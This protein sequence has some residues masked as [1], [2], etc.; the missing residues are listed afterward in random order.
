MKLK[1]LT[2]STFLVAFSI[3]TL[4]A[5]QKVLSVQVPDTIEAPKFGPNGKHYVQVGLEFG[6]FPMKTESGLQYSPFR[7]A[8]VNLNIRYKYK[9]SNFYALGGDFLLGGLN[10]VRPNKEGEFLSEEVTLL[11]PSF[12]SLT[13]DYIGLGIYQ[14]FNFGKRGNS[15][16]FFMDMGAFS[17]I[18]IFSQHY[19]RYKAAD[20]EV[21]KIFV[22]ERGL[23]YSEFF[24]YGYTLRLGY[25]NYALVAK[26]FA[27]DFFSGANRAVNPYMIGVEINFD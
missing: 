11:N 4:H 7:S 8:L 13:N 16:G 15:L 6:F 21:R 2:L 5:Q 17:Q 23:D 14:R 26:Y 25:N 1:H 12:E 24:V 10:F 19:Y 18:L 9:I 27:S 20:P 22:K 3:F